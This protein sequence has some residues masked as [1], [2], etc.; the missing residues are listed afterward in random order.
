VSTYKV[1]VY[2]PTYYEIEA[3]D[4]NEAK[5]TAEYLFKKENSEWIGNTDEIIEF[6]AEA[7]L[8]T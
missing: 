1:R 2:I 5:E 4:E 6:I 7:T 8:L 3:G